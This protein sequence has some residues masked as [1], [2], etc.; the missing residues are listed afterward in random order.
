MDNRCIGVFDSGIG[1]LTVV[2]EIMHLLPSE[3][4]YYLGDTARYPYGPRSREN[5]QK[6]TL[7][8]A[9]FLLSHKIKMLVVAC[10]TASAHALRFLWEHIKDIP[11]IGVIEPGA[12]AAIAQT[13]N[14]R[15]GVIGTEGTIASGAYRDALIR[16][17]PAASVIAKACPL[18]VPLAEEGF[19]EGEIPQ[20]IADHYLEFL[21]NENIDTLILGCTHY[22]LLESVIQKAV[23]DDIALIH[24]AQWTAREIKNMLKTLRITAGEKANA[25]ENSR[26]FVTDAPERFCRVGEPFLERKLQKVEKITLD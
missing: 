15:I 5:I 13:K 20:K 7:Q 17:E 10:N 9:D 2:K 22:P 11:I 14:K 3:T 21:K 26:F 16:L 19:R 4:I 8:I 12:K 25:F 6:L 1:G 18:F 23:G 24:S